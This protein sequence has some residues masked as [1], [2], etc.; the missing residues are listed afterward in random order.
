VVAGIFSADNFFPV[1]GV[2]NPLYKSTRNPDRLVR[3]PLKIAFLIALVFCAADG[4]RK[5]LAARRSPGL[6]RCT[7]RCRN[8]TYLLETGI[9]RNLANGKTS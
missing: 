6:H 2:I 3:V 8:F 4:S 7:Y 1:R 5:L 9:S